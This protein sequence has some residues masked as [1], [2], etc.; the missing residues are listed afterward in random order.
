MEWLRENRSS[1]MAAKLVAEAK[2]QV[3][4]HAFLYYFV[5]TD[6]CAQVRIRIWIPTSPPHPL[7]IFLLS[8]S[9][10]RDKSLCLPNKSGLF[11]CFLF[12]EQASYDQATE[13][14]KQSAAPSKAWQVLFSLGNSQII[15]PQPTSVFCL[16]SPC[17]AKY[18]M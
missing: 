15:V 11:L 5:K 2:S 1:P 7:P 14:L 9:L 8:T 17:S 3:R 10:P 13:I 4:A 18:L 6:V 16:P 12:S